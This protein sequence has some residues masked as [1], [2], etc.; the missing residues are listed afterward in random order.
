MGLHLP[1]QMEKNIENIIEYNTE[2]ATLLI[3]IALSF[4]S[5][6]TRYIRRHYMES[7]PGVVQMRNKRQGICLENME[8]DCQ[9]D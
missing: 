6:Y 1:V 4:H 5:N 7:I 2:R 8:L 3:I 9:F